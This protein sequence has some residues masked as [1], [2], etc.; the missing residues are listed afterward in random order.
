MS[1]G[2]AEFM[3][4]C[5]ALSVVVLFELLWLW[6]MLCQ[7]ISLLPQT[8]WPYVTGGVHPD[9]SFRASLMNLDYQCLRANL[10]P[11]KF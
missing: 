10:G 11:Q 5:K 8:L 4:L 2:I 7:Q 6:Q 1:G 9:E 3:R